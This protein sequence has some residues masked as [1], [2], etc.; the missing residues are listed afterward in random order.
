MIDAL[1]LVFAIGSPFLFKALRPERA[2]LVI[3][4]GGWVL[5]PVGHYPPGSA[6]SLFPYWITGLAVPSDMLLTKAWIVPAVALSGS[7][8]FDRAMLRA[9]QPAWIDLPIGL[10]CLWPLLESPFV[11]SADP[12]GWLA[13]LYL[14]GAWGLPW[15]LGRVY[16]CTMLRQRD[17]ARG[18]AWSGLACLPFSVV[19]GLVG[20]SLYSAVYES[21]PFRNDGA[22]RYTGFRPLGFF[23][24]GNQFG[25]WISLAALMALWIARTESPG[26]RAHRVARG[27]AAVVTTMA[28]AAQSIGG[29]VL[30]VSGC[31]FLSICRWIRPR[32]L[33][34][35]VFSVVVVAGAVYVSG[36]VPVTRLARDTVIGQH[37]VSDLR[38]VGRGSLSWR[39]SQD[40][41]LLPDATARPLTGEAQWNWWRAHKVRPW[42]LAM[43][44]LGQFGLPGMAL[45][46]AA[47]LVPALRYTLRVPRGSGWLGDGVAL[48][49]ATVVVLATVD[50]LMNSFIFFPALLAAGAIAQ[51]EPTGRIRGEITRIGRRAMA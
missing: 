28:L 43:L 15:L 49:L 17:L 21:H 33:V 42:G 6:E 36:R 34:V 20:P 4:L 26:G 13:S 39:I 45:S 24:N 41:K 14:A 22:T 50:A 5:L 3:F 9:F 32:G 51:A 16:F 44:V 38:A 46:L 7:A 35:Y 11:T 25:L 31:L 27:I 48:A 1:F 8:L 2:V 19:E 12:A 29:I 30:L 18:I 40:Q 10:W 37:I 23:E 47:L